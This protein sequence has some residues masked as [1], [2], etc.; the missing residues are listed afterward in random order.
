MASWFQDGKESLPVHLLLQQECAQWGSE[1]IG[2]LVQSQ[3]MTFIH[4][5]RESDQSTILVLHPPTQGPLPVR[6]ELG[7]HPCKAN[8]GAR[9]NGQFRVSHTPKRN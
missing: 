6:K 5:D 1:P 8:K 7:K 4:S 9:A 3:G 2:C